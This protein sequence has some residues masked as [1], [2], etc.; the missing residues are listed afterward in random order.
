[1]NWVTIVASLVEQGLWAG[2]WMVA[3]SHLHLR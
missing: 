2:G 1:M 3:P